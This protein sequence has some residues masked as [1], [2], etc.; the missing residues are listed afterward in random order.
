MHSSLANDKD[1]STAA[2][3]TLVEGNRIC[4]FWPNIGE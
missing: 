1:N 3:S 2:A 4:I